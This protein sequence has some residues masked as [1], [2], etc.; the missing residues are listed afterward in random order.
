M[1]HGAS[2]R[3]L[4]GGSALRRSFLYLFC[5][6]VF[7]FLIGPIFV[8]VPLSFSSAPYLT[9]PPPGWSLQWYLSY[10]DSEQWFDATVLSFE[11]GF[12]VTVLATTFGT[13][14][15]LA[16]RRCGPQ[17]RGAITAFLVSP[18]IV[19]V[20]IFAIAIYYLYA[21][22]HLVGTA[23]GIILA[24]TVLAIPYVV[25]TVSAAFEGFDRKF[26]WA[27]RTL[28]AGGVRTFFEVTLP[29]IRGGVISGALFAFI[30]SFD[31]VVIAIFV[32]GSSAITL[33]KQMWAGVT[34][35]IDP[36]VS[37]VSTLVTMVSIMVI[38]ALTFIVRRDERM[39]MTKA[40]AAEANE[41]G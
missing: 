21:R 32:G 9:F 31:E 19:P 7:F 37:A 25:I 40:N 41:H 1:D 23:T 15:V 24:H 8:I 14:A 39:R 20:I 18:M 12:V 4:R 30:T 27:A 11:I 35:E 36:T 5:A 17:L 33:P 13:A 34:N 2:H 26:E 3:S 38:A 6:L 22:V 28:G 10:L 29:L 16:L